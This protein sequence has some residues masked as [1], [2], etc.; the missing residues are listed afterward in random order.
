MRAGLGWALLKAGKGAEAAVELR[1]VLDV[2]P[3]N[4]LALDGLKALPGR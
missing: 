4:A 3:R 1:A 2:S